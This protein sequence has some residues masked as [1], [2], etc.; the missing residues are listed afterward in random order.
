ML[1]QKG[2]VNV[3]CLPSLAISFSGFQNGVVV[4]CQAG[5]SF[6]IQIEK[7]WEDLPRQNKTHSKLLYNLREFHGFY[8]IIVR[9]PLFQLK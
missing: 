2:K 7:L 4:P 9:D 6:M 1:G 3:P 5:C 8:K